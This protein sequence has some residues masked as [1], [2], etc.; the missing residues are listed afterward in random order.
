MNIFEYNFY[1]Y[2]ILSILVSAPVPFLKMDLLKDFNVIEQLVY[3][4]F[5]LFI[6]FLTIYICYQ[7]KPIKELFKKKKFDT[8]KSFTLFL[9]VVTLGLILNGYIL[10]NEGEVIKFKSYQR[11]L[12]MILLVFIGQCLFN[13][14]ITFNIFLGII[15]IILG[16]Y[17]IE[18]K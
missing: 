3:S 12:S 14:K 9:I 7:K 4:N 17:L 2:L 5:F 8:I 18:K 1:N 16:L 15:S 13:E 10:K 11:S 6:V